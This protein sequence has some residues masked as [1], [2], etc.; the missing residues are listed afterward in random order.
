M[1]SEPRSVKLVIDWAARFSPRWPRWPGPTPSWPVPQAGGAQIRWLEGPPRPW[2]ASDQSRGRAVDPTSAQAGQ[3]EP[4]R[5]PG[6]ICHRVVAYAYINLLRT[7]SR[8]AAP[9]DEGRR[10][11]SGPALR[12][13][14]PLSFGHVPRSSGQVNLTSLVNRRPSEPLEREG[15]LRR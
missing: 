9:Q 7:R 13:G 15:R 1:P 10:L 12:N 4:R 5:A 6:V 8:C 2:A 3:W 11:L 14:V